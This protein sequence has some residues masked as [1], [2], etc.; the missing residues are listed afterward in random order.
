MIEFIGVGDCVKCTSTS[1][2]I[3]NILVKDSI[4]AKR[5]TYVGAP[6]TE[7]RKDADAIMENNTIF[8]SFAPLKIQ[9]LSD[10]GIE[11]KDKFILLDKNFKIRY[12]VSSDKYLSNNFIKEMILECRKIAKE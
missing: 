7:R 6:I 4:I 8:D 10:N 12:K 11:I 9:E 3:K 2:T 1:T 5:C